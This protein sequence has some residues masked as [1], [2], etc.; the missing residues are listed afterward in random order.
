MGDWVPVKKKKPLSYKSTFTYSNVAKHS[1]V[2]VYI[3]TELS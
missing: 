3:V 2:L 1:F